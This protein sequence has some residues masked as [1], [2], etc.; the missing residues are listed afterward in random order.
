MATSGAR[1]PITESL[2]RP[3]KVLPR[4][5]PRQLQAVITSSRTKWSRMRR[6]C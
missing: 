1:D 2:K 6:G 4:E 5:I 3:G